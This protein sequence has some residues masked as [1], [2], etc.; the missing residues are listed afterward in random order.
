MLEQF[1]ICLKRVNFYLRFLGLSLN[2]DKNKTILEHIRSHWLYIAHSV[3]LNVEVVAQILWVMEAIKADKRFVEITRL[4]PCLVLCFIC[5]LKTISILYYARYNFEFIETMKGLLLKQM[6][7]EEEGNHFKK[8]VID[9]HVLMLTNITKKTIYLIIVGLSMFSLAPVFIIVPNYFKTHELI[10]EMPFI[11]Y[12]PFNEFDPW[13][14][15]FVYIHQV[16][17]GK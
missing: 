13:I 8:K 9:T 16:W 4:I 2:R 11:A 15:P 17:S 6:D 12:Y 1:E 3:S 10:L 7:I 14:Y 5:N